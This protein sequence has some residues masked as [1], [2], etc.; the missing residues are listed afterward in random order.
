MDGQQ[1]T[2]ECKCEIY[3]DN[4]QNFKRYG[5]PKAQLVIADV[6]YC[7]D[8]Q[9]QCWTRRGWINYNELT[10]DDVVLTLNPTT[11][12]MAYSGIEDII[13]RDN[14]APMY[15]FQ[16]FTMDFLVT[17][18]HRMFCHREISTKTF[19]GVPITRTNKTGIRLS[20]DVN[21]SCYI[22][23]SGYTW[24][25]VL[26]KGYISIPEC[27]INTNGNQHVEPE[28]H[29]RWENWL[30]FFG[31]WLADGCTCNSKAKNGRQ[32]YTVSIKQAGDNRKK[33]HEILGML[34][35]KYKEYKEKKRNESN[36]NIF[37]KQLWLYLRQFGK[38]QEKYIP[39]EIL[40][41]PT[42]YL[43]IFW[44][45]YTFGDSCKNGFGMKISTVSR[46][47]I[48]G[49]QE[50]ALKLGVICQVRQYAFPKWSNPLYSFQFNKNSK[51][52]RFSSKKRLENYHGKVWCIRCKQN[53]VFLVRRNGIVNF[54]GNCLGTNAYGSSPQWYIGGDNANGESDKAA[55]PF[56]NTDMNFNLVEYMHFCNRLLIKEP[57][58]R[59][60]APAMIVFCAFEQ[61]HELSEVAAKYGFKH[62]GP[63]A[64]ERQ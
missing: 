36:F 43:K 47:L 1:H 58:E 26:E 12:E 40:D 5:I 13:I 25:T 59:N 61:A 44:D 53:S 63:H 18:N 9:T 27:D 21:N 19:G 28:K 38:S 37:S 34:P 10:L 50:I 4:F 14:V 30:P 64:G 3:R 32:L 41:L 42:E 62:G 17:E 8:E 29:I 7:Y 51:H 24:S 22:P 52:S 20:Q 16:S 33:V 39:R 57:K 55:K 15:S 56:F 23:H 2:R 60:K 48:E 31:L 54:C 45:A 35:F 6:P 49:L 11:L 46:R